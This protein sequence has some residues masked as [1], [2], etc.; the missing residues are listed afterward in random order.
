MYNIGIDLGGTNIKVGVVDER[1][2]IVGKSNIKTNLPRP[3][4]E[5]AESI[6][7]GVR[8]ACADAGIEV[9]AVNSIGIGTPGTANRNTGVVLY[10]CNLDFH[11]FALGKILSQKL[12]TEVFVENDAN[13]AAFGEVVNGAGK[14][15]KNVVVVTLGTGVGGGIIIDGKIYTG[16]NFCGAEL[17]HTV[18][19]YG[20]RKCG[21]GR[22][23]CF[24]AYSSATALINMTREAMEADPNTKMWELSGNSLENVDGKTAFDGMRAGDPAAKRVVD[25][26]INY[27]GCGL[28]N[29]V[30][31]FQPELLLIG[32]GICKEGEN[33]TVP[34]RRIIEEES[35]CIDPNRSTKLDIA[36]LGN[37]AGIIGAAY[38]Y[39]LK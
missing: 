9:S 32:G 23:G 17:G 1:G 3:S 25:T 12:G 11:D 18:I 13:A 26:Y 28:A 36:K 21:C 10:S 5:I 31:T 20:G 14:G 6:A 4:E 24:E 38:L 15:Y 7:E 37:D 33:L 35:Y 27:L 2:E 16:F 39:T 19:E 29:I 34:L 22:K 30:N 8:L